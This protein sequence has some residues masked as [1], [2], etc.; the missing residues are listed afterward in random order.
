SHRHHGV[1]L[2]AWRSGLFVPSTSVA[3]NKLDGRGSFESNNSAVIIC[4]ELV[5]VN[6][7]LCISLTATDVLY[8]I[9]MGQ[10]GSKLRPE[11][12][13]DIRQCTEFTE[14][15]IQEWY[16]GFM[17]DCPYG[18]LTAEEF[19]KIYAYLFPY[20]DA[21]KFAEHVFRIFDSNGDGSIDFR[22]FMCALSITTRG[23]VEQK[24]EWAFR[25]YDVDGDGY[26]SRQEM[27]DVVSAIYKM[28]GN[29]LKIPDDEA[30][31]EK[32]TDKIFK[33]MD[34]NADG[35]LSLEEFIRGAKSD[36]SIVRLLEEG[37]TFVK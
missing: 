13:E 37:V 14:M 21:S 3:K 23:R 20:G 26:I 2:H 22:E 35:L 24:L 12:I 15:E 9:V 34:K 16:K 1:R 30:T 18:H 4:R 17:K 10:K 32:K 11:A 28:I 33:A 19:K 25:M 8:C 29:V 36:K 6:T 27:L 5:V 7:L 31:P